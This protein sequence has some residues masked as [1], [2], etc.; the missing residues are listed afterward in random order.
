MLLFYIIIF[1]LLSA[2]FSGAEIAFISASKLKVELKRKENNLS[3]AI[4]GGFMDHPKDFLATTLVGNNIA[5][6]VFTY[7]MARLLTPLAEP[8]LTSGIVIGF[9]ITVL[10]TI[11]VLI[12][13]EYL[14]KTVSRL[15]ADTILYAIAI[16]LKFFRFLFYIPT[17][18]MIFLSEMLIRLFFKTSPKDLDET[19]SKVDL[20]HFIQ[21]TNHG[22]KEEKIDT[23]LFTNALNL[24]LLKVREC[25]VPRTELVAIS[26][27]STIEELIEVYSSSNLSRII[28]I[29]EDLDNVLGYVHHQQILQSPASIRSMV[30]DIT[31][32]PEV[33]NVHDLLNKFIIE[34]SSIAIVVDEFGGTSGVITMEDVL[35]EIFG[36]IE[37]EHDED[38]YIL[39]QLG[40]NEFR[41]SGRVEVSD[42]NEKFEG[43]QIPEG[44]YNT[45][46]GY[47]VMTTQNIPDQGEE[48]FL[49]GKRFIIESVSE[50]KIETIRILIEE[51]E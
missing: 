29:E 44:E 28:V 12:F 11:V 21:M 14:P 19:F 9:I 37:D 18:L 6:V 23:N 26:A 15:F 16:P 51:Q 4:V 39:E 48:I 40:E 50:T 36:E 38:E 45:L 31:F 46:S 17:K 41:I 7:L 32:I 24:N 30:M 1:L 22:E 49:E 34:K 33:M 42:I 2:F 47:L 5:L 25:M 27:D 8:F 20:E 35:E 13:G 43:I 3:G 10:T